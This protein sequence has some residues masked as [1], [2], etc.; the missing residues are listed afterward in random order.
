MEFVQGLLMKS[1]ILPGVNHFPEDTQSISPAP[2][3][4]VSLQKGFAVT[5]CAWQWN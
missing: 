4:C 3:V 2:C 1:L 5:A